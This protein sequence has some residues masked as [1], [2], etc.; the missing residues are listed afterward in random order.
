VIAGM[1]VSIEPAANC[2]N[3]DNVVP[4][5]DG[6]LGCVLGGAVGVAQ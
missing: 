2:G 1:A 4:A 3:G 5:H 6:G